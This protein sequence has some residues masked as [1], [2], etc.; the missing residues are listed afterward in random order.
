MS[1]DGLGMETVHKLCYLLH[2]QSDRYRDRGW[3]Q[4]D[5][6]SG[7]LSTVPR[8]VQIL[9]LKLAKVRKVHARY[10]VHRMAQHI[11]HPTMASSHT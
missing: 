6:A 10:S 2:C 7:A 4:L 5:T 11:P 9:S 3:T 1:K 8:I